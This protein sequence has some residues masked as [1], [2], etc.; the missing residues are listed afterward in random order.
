MSKNT[1][2]V[3]HYEVYTLRKNTV[4]LEGENN[5]ERSEEISIFDD[6]ELAEAYMSKLQ[7]GVELALKKDK[8]LVSLSYETYPRW[9]ESEPNADMFNLPFNPVHK[10]EP[11]KKEVK[12]VG[13][14][15][16]KAKQ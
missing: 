3:K 16:P 10:E 9:V 11:V 7:E 1:R 14:F 8:K 15:I 6:I 5:I 4:R 13:K 12:K 2:D